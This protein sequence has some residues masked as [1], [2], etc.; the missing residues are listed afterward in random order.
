MEAQIP[1]DFDLLVSSEGFFTIVN[2][3][4]VST[5]SDEDIHCCIRNQLDLQSDLNGLQL[6]QS[7]ITDLFCLISG[8]EDL[9]VANKTSLYDCLLELCTRAL[10]NFND[11]LDVNGK[12]A[13]KILTYYNFILTQKG[14]N[15]HSKQNTFNGLGKANKTKKS[16]KTT[17]NKNNDDIDEFDWVAFRTQCLDI[18]SRVMSLD[19]SGLWSMGVIPENF[20]NLVWTYPLQLLEN[21]PTGVG[22]S[23]HKEIAVRQKCVEIIAKCATNFGNRGFIALTTAMVDALSRSEHMDKLITDIC[24]RSP[25]NLSSEVMSEIGR[26]NMNELAKSGSGAKNV[27]SF[28]INFAESNPSIMASRLPVV[29]HQLDSEIWSIRSAILQAMGHVVTYIHNVCDGNSI[30]DDEED[31]PSKDGE[32]NEIEEVT[33]NERNNDGEK[34]TV[35]DKEKEV[36]NTDGEPN[37]SGLQSPRN[38]I[39]RSPQSHPSQSKHNSSKALTNARDNFLDMLVERTHDVN[40]FVR[41]AVLKIWISLLEGNSVP[42]RRMPAIAEIAVDRLFDKTAAVRKAAVGLLVALLENNPFAARLDIAPFQSRVNVLEKD[43]SNRILDL[44]HNAK[45]AERALYNTHIEM[46]PEATG[47]SSEV[48]CSSSPTIIVKEDSDDMVM[49]VDEGNGNDKDKSITTTTEDAVPVVVAPS[50]PEDEEMDDDFPESP[51]VVQDNEVITL[52]AELD[53]CTSAINFLRAIESGVPK[54]E[55]MVRSKTTGDVVEALRFFTRAVNFSIQGS[56]KS[57]R[58]TFSLIWHHEENIRLECLSSFRMVFLTDGACSGDAKNLS[59]NEVGENIVALC[60]RCGP[61]ELTSVEKIIGEIFLKGQIDD[62]VIACL[63]ESA[64]SVV[65]KQRD[66]SSPSSKSK[67]KSRSEANDDLGFIIQ[68]LA[69]VCKFQPTLITPSKLQFIIQNGLGCFAIENSDYLA[70][71]CSAQMLQ[72]VSAYIPAKGTPPSEIMKTA[73]LSAVPYLCSIIQAK[74]VNLNADTIADDE[75]EVRAWFSVCEEAMHALF[76]IHPCPDKYIPSMIGEMYSVITKDGGSCSAQELASI[77]F[78]LGQGAIC[79]LVF[80]ERLANI[81][82]KADAARSKTSPKEAETEE[83]DAMEEEMGMAAAEDAEH[84]RIYQHVTEKELV[85][86]NLLGRFHPFLAFIV[87]NQNGKYSHRLVRE[88]GVLALCRYMAVSCE[89]CEKYL[90]LIFTVLEK[91]NSE[92]V[93]TSI[94]IALGDLAFRFPNSLE[95]WTARFYAR[96]TDEDVVVRYNTLMT[97]THLILNDMIKVKGQVTHIVM[98]LNDECEKIRSLA[99]LF[100]LELAKRSNNPVYNLLGDIIGQLSQSASAVTTAA[101]STHVNSTTI[102]EENEVAQLIP[103]AG[104]RPMRVLTE[105]EFQSTMGFLLSFVKKEKQG[106]SLLERLL[107]RIGLAQTTEQRRNLGY[108][109][110]Q[111]PITEKGV[112]K[113]TEMIREFM[114]CLHDDDV[115]E[116]FCKTLQKCKKSAN[117]FGRGANKDKDSNEDGNDVQTSGTNGEVA[118]S[119]EEASSNAKSAVEEFEALMEAVRNAGEGAD[120]NIDIVTASVP[121]PGTAKKAPNTTRKKPKSTVKKKATQTVAKQT[122]KKKTKK[123]V[124]SDEESDDGEDFADDSDAEEVISQSTRRQRKPLV[125]IN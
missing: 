24:S 118:V 33:S 121:A 22:G 35:E 91:E 63:W 102:D 76:H 28:L 52:R 68:V 64:S 116:Y 20:M 99:S 12:N 110:A 114:D 51:E 96:L 38:T 79:G 27:G 26:I 9:S 57:L 2:P 83:A 92:F 55:Q 119:N 87:A 19:Q 11:K 71:K 106:D 17:K 75:K 32:A 4:E 21:K 122:A 46:Q 13:I 53:Y 37:N 47:P 48:T 70:M 104:T 56:A 60:K 80:T 42:V 85:V 74:C 78:V 15:F 81:A 59:P 90:P 1:A 109:I 100:F 58:S 49:A 105:T 30:L 111:L 69:M 124:Q 7:N 6:E 25:A 73:M 40:A 97:L 34:E 89:I 95:P 44:W 98:C 107:T 54:V 50:V 36:N 108:C 62:S 3:W 14:E 41:A 31:A 72:C 45:E 8:F 113:M 103:T 18:Y 94:V 65:Q 117:N 123:I 115:Y 84:D 10:E 101:V 77:L 5:L 86:Q 112:K 88:T 61:S 67:T 39:N 16:T 82:K 43:L 29:I 120:I 125:D 66:S 23:G 93:R